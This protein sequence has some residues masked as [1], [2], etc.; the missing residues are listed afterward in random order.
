MA[1]NRRHEPEQG[2]YKHKY[3]GIKSGWDLPDGGKPPLSKRKLE[4]IRAYELLEKRTEEEY[5]ERAE[6]T[7]K[8]REENRRIKEENRR[9]IE[10]KRKQGEVP[11]VVMPEPLSYEEILGEKRIRGTAK[12]VRSDGIKS[13]SDKDWKRGR[14]KKIAIVLLAVIVLIG[15]ADLR[16]AFGPPI[17]MADIS[18]YEDVEIEVEGLTDEPFTITAGELAGMRLTK[19][20]VD[21]HQ[22]E[23]AE[24]EV[25]ELGRAIGPTL[26]EFLKQYGKSTDDFRSMKVYN[27]RDVSTAYVRT[28]KEKTIVLSVAN[29]RKALGEREAPL[30][31]AIS[32]EDPGTWSGWVRRI[33]FTPY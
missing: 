27:E 20:S 7:R 24:D 14:N 23:L 1:I 3:V 29:G 13:V 15:A 18:R 6:I 26:D 30:R 16:L 33:V 8:V 5:I 2:S 17:L 31:I 28:M 12:Q 19:V 4:S 9:I 32:D 11:E 21:V 22:G 10:E 25:P